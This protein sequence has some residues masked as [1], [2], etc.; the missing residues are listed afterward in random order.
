MGKPAAAPFQQV[1]IPMGFTIGNTTIAPPT[2]AISAAPTI[3]TVPNQA[4]P[5]L[6][7]VDTQS[8]TTQIGALTAGA[9]ASFSITIPLPNLPVPFAPSATEAVLFTT[10]LA[11]FALPAGLALN[12]IATTPQAFTSSAAAP[13]VGAQLRAGAQYTGWQIVVSGQVI[14]VVNSSAGTISATVVAMLSDVAS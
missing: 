7:G 8:G 5:I 14:A 3:G 2:T 1:N 9:S 6:A 10:K 13:V 11:A 4:L 12:S